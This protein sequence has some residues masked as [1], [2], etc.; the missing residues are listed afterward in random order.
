[1]QVEIDAPIQEI[2]W[3]DIRSQ[4]TSKKDEILAL[5]DKAFYDAE[6]VNSKSVDLLEEEIAAYVGVKYAVCLNSGTDALIF[7]MRGLGIGP[8][9][10]VITPPN[11]FI[12]STSSI[13]HIGATPIFV[14]VAEDQNIDPSKIEAAITPKTK[15]IMVVHLTGRVC[16]MREIKEIA[17]K[18]GLF[19]IE[20]A[21]Q[22]FGSKYNGMLTGSMGD[23]GC[24]SAHPLKIFNSAGDA[25]FITTNNLEIYNRAR[26]LRNHGLI[27]R[28]TVTEWGYVSR[29]N[30]VQ[31]ELLRMRL[32]EEF[33]GNIERRRKNA[34]VYKRLLN[35]EFV[36]IPETDEN[37][38]HT[39]QCFVIQVDRRDELQQH[40][41]RHGIKTA[42]HYPTPIH[43]QPVAKY[44]GY[45][46][47]DF[48]YTEKQA[49]SIITI[50]VH[51]FLKEHE[52]VYVCNT[53]NDFFV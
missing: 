16:K 34:A 10:E 39:Y 38:F 35:A 22:A 21:A 18:H 49:K 44:L 42:I 3:V 14:D 40:L 41:L 12:A 43:L 6:F 28:S 11:S 45:K 5:V 13:V 24:F 36:F 47:G 53:I 31:A 51:Q 17:T 46:E 20:D 27:D 23:A 33:Q 19:I 1:M 4:Y 52:I 26:S 8:G 15:A 29:L 2:S 9:D 25:G 32:A 30:T 48:P 50:P 7:A 37:I